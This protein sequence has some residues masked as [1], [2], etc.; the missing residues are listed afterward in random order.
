[1]TAAD[2]VDDVQRPRQGQR[3]VW[4]LPV[5]RSWTGIRGDTDYA[6]AKPT[7]WNMKTDSINEHDCTVALST[8]MSS[9]STDI[10]SDYSQ[11]WWKKGWL[12]ASKWLSASTSQHIST[13]SREVTRSHATSHATSHK[14]IREWCQKMHTFTKPN[15]NFGYIHKSFRGS[16]HKKSREVTQGYNI[17]CLQ[18]Q[19]FVYWFQHLKLTIRAR[20]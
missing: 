11:N 9:S 5:R 18:Y 8:S 19:P 12:R 13:K 15:C 1:M 14:R 4:Q 17:I 20:L 2:R 3:P 10:L 7:M 6:A 16:C